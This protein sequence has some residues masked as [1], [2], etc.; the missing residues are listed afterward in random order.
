MD[1]RASMRQLPALYAVT[2]KETAFLQPLFFYSDT[3]KFFVSIFSDIFFIE[4]ER[5]QAQSFVPTQA[6][7]S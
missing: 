7:E 6:Y 1:L 4:N 5:R 2:E 3:K